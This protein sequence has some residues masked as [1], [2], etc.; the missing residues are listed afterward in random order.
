MPPTKDDLLKLKLS[1]LLEQ[2]NE[3]GVSQPEID[4]FERD[5]HALGTRL[6]RARHALGTRTGGDAHARPRF[7]FESISPRVSAET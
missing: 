7:R 1:G 6:A 5:W 4:A 3:A 2:A